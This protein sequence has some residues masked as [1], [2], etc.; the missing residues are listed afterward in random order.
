M[1]GA[2]YRDPGIVAVYVIAEIV[3]YL[4][5]QWVT[6]ELRYRVRKRLDRAG[7]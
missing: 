2:L 1:A 7:K 3:I 4:V 5:N 6:Y